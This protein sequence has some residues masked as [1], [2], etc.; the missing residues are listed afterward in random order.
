[1]KENN[2]KLTRSEHL[3]AIP[4]MIGVS[5]WM[6]GLWIFN[7]NFEQSELNIGE[8]AVGLDFQMFIVAGLT[9][10]SFLQICNFFET[11]LETG[12]KLTIIGGRRHKELRAEKNKRAKEINAHLKEWGEEQR[13]ARSEHLNE[14][15]LMIGVNVLMAG[16][17]VLVVYF[18][19]SELKDWELLGLGFLGFFL[20]INCVWKVLKEA[21]RA[22]QAE[23]E[24][25]AKFKKSVEEVERAEEQRRAGEAGLVDFEQGMRELNTYLRESGISESTIFNIQAGIERIVGKSGE[26]TFDSARPWRGFFPK[27][28][29]TSVDKKTVNH[30]DCHTY[31]IGNVVS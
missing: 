28:I 31:M 19:Q 13:L 22:V 17:L 5:V 7:W 30:F 29:H 18:I 27:I 3:N 26:I 24:I 15:P 8:W 4:L 20:I 2:N 25:I 16:Y 11:M 12:C 14:I 9:I 21:R 1:M 10:L 23:E 6:A